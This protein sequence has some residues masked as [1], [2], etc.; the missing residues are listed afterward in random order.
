M[1]VKRV[2][3]QFLLK[4]CHTN[5]QN[6]VSLLA[7]NNIY[8]LNYHKGHLTRIHMKACENLAYNDVLQLL[9]FET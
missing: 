8:L 4:I 3:E 9:N 6:S 1:S 2:F 5:S 7:Y